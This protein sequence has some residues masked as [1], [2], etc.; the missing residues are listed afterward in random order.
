MFELKDHLCK[1]L[2]MSRNHQNEGDSKVAYMSIAYTEVKLGK[3]LIDSLMGIGTW[4]SWFNV[5]GADIQP[6]PWTLKVDLK[7]A[8]AFKD[9]SVAIRLLSVT[10]KTIPVELEFDGCRLYF[11]K[12]KLMSGGEVLTD[13]HIHVMDAKDIEWNQIGASEY[14]EVQLSCGNGVVIERKSKRQMALDLEANPNA[15]QAVD[16]E[17]G[18]DDQGVP[19]QTFVWAQHGETQQVWKGARCDKPEGY[20]EID[21]P[22]GSRSEAEQLKQQEA[23]NGGDEPPVAADEPV[24]EDP[25]PVAE[26]PEDLAKFETNLAAAVGARRKRG[27]NVID[28]TSERVRH[29]DRQ[30]GKH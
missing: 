28:G 4:A 18:S 14:T 5:N 26:T 12:F 21:P 6:M 2:A 1:Q 20:V 19:D 13:M 16:G 27:S 24:G 29:R 10:K 30:S 3:E 11:D 23:A 9:V 7:C 8:D 22:A 15:E 17:P 25:A